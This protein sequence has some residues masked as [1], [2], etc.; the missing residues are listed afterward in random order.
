MSVYFE[1]QLMLLTNKKQSKFH[2]AI[3]I[4]KMLIQRAAQ[5]V[6]YIRYEIKAE[7]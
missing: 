5:L 3:R 1:K 2:V 6:N 4:I 7:P